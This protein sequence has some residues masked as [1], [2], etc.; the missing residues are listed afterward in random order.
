MRNSNIIGLV[1]AFLLGVLAT[2]SVMYFT[3]V[4]P[5]Q[6]R[7]DAA[8]EHL[9]TSEGN[10]SQMGTLPVPATSIVENSRITRSKLT[11]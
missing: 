9:D 6:Q 2:F 3:Q 10:W 5:R 1:L 4:Q 7:I 11:D 8:L